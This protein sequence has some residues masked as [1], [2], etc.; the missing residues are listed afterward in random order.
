MIYTPRIRMRPITAS[1]MISFPRF[2]LLN[3]VP[4]IYKNPPYTIMMA[5]AMAEIPTMYRFAA[6][7]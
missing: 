7:T 5:A 6:L 3:D 1:W 4:T 2:T